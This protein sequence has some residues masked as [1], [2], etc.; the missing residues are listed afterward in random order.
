VLDPRSL[1]TLSDDVDVDL[2]RPVLVHALTGFVDAGSATRLVTDHLLS[3]LEHEVVATFDA[4]Q[5]V[6]YRSRRPAMVFDRDHYTSFEEPRLQLHAVRDLDGRAFLLLTGPE[7]DT[8]WERFVVAVRELVERF[9]VST[10]I[11]LHAIGM[12]VPHTRPLGVLGHANQ[13]GLVP[14]SQ[15]W[16]G[17]V[18]IPGSAAAL[19]E[20]RLGESGHPALGF[21][22]QVP[23]YLAESSYPDAAAALVDRLADEAGLSVPRA[24]L[25]SAAEQTR[26]AIAAQV[27]ASEEVG[28]VV[29]AL[30]EQY[31]AYMGARGRRSL[32]AAEETLPSADELAAE[33][34]QFLKGEAADGE[35]G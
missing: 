1:Y 20:L 9:S 21:V 5:L 31:D 3:S 6:D 30:E 19:L 29:A 11:G 18:R 23:H 7:P 17:T 24:A 27:A 32:L 12:P 4:D 13:A 34:E 14:Q 33:V 26:E 2:D 16:P 10:T 15:T 25:L 35:Q 28:Q 22:V 8:Q